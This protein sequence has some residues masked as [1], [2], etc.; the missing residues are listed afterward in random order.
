DYLVIEVN[1]KSRLVRRNETLTI[2]LGDK[3]LIRKAALKGSAEEP[4]VVNLVGF[5]GGNG[6]NS[7]EDR[8]HLVDT[9]KDLL[10]SWSI[11]K[12]GE[13][14]LIKATTGE[15]LHGEITLSLVS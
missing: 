3:V 14:Y 7:A 12:K 15:F 10:V 1:G 8:G 6:K 9:A 4:Q 2:V 13:Q 11:D 5:V